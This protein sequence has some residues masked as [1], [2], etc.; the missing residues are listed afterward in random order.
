MRS[1]TLMRHQRAFLRSWFELS[2]RALL[3]DTDGDGTLSAGNAHEAA[4]TNGILDW[5][6]GGQK[7]GVE[8]T[9]YLELRLAAIDEAVDYDRAVYEH[10]AFAAAIEE[11]R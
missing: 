5:L 10:D 4:T 11:L 7:P 1:G 3:D 6:R 8:A 2:L 9:E